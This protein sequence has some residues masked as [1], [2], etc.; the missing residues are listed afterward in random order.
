MKSSGRNQPMKKKSHSAFGKPHPK[1]QFTLDEDRELQGFVQQYGA[2]DWDIISK[3]MKNRNAR[4]CKERW[5]K[6][7]SPDLNN[8]PWTNAE[9]KLL[10]SKVQELGQKW[11]KISKYFDKRT[12]ANLKNRWNVLLRRAKLYDGDLEAAVNMSAKYSSANSP[13]TPSEDASSPD[14]TQNTSETTDVRHNQVLFSSLNSTIDENHF[15]AAFDQCLMKE[16]GPLP[17]DSLEECLFY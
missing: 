1:Q 2:N 10:L 6:Y 9:D 17:F 4:Q 11:V 16:F 8:S 14:P 15:N 7:L 13:L 12:D 3:L 5:T